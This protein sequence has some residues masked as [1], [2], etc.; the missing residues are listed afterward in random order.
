MSSLAAAFPESHGAHGTVRLC[1]LVP[2]TRAAMPAPFALRGKGEGEG[3]G[4]T[5][6]HMTSPCAPLMAAQHPLP[7]M[8]F[9]LSA[10]DKSKPAL[11]P[12]KRIGL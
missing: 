12:K 10:E 5:L 4:K 7:P 6:A 1:L 8:G 11:L 9:G 3:E 2:A